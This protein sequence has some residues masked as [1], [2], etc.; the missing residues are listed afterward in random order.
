MAHRCPYLVAA[1]ET[2]RRGH[3][4]GANPALAEVLLDFEGDLSRL[5]V[6]GIFDG[7]G[8]VKRGQMAVGEFDIDD[9]SDDLNDFTDVGGG[10]GGGNHSVFLMFVRT[11]RKGE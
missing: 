1:L 6:H 7:Q 8:V 11:E 5:A 10:R 9:R 3:G 2:F 4:H